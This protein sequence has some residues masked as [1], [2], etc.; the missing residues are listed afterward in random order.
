MRAARTTFI[1]PSIQQQQQQQQ[2]FASIYQATVSFNPPYLSIWFVGLIFDLHKVRILIYFTIPLFGEVHFFS[3]YFN[4]ITL[5]AVDQL[6][7]PSIISVVSDF[8]F[9]S[10]CLII[11]FPSL[12]LFPFEVMS[13]C[14]F[15]LLWSP[16][17]MLAIKSNFWSILS[18]ILLL[19]L[20]QRIFSRSSPLVPG[21]LV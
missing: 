16:S 3:H 19:L 18:T 11:C 20:L 1:F 10:R 12:S 8:E 14:L 15:H 6:F 7:W 17:E 13:L 2:L 21:W 4:C 9:C 5:L